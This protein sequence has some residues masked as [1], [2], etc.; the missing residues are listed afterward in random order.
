MKISVIL[1]VFI[2]KP[3]AQATVFLERSLETVINQN[4]PDDFEVIVVD[5]G[6]PEPVADVMGKTVYKTDMRIRWERLPRNS[7]LVYALNFGLRLA[8]YPFIARI[9]ADDCWRP[10]KI[11]KQMRLFEKDPD[12]SIVGT[13]MSLV[14]ENGNVLEDIV[15]PGSWDGVLDLFRNVGCPFPHGSI[16]ALKSVFMLLG[17]YP[18][19]T[20]FAHCEDFAL[21]GL[22]LR[23]F[24]PAMIEEVLYDYTVSESSVSAIHAEH[25][26][27]GSEYVHRQ[28]LSL[29]SK[30]I[31]E[32]LIR[33]GEILGLSVLDVGRLCFLIWK[34]SPT[35]TLPKPA[36][37]PMQILMPDRRLSLRRS[38]GSR[39]HP[40][41]HLLSTGGSEKTDHELITVDI[42]SP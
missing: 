9:D 38:G 42:C 30:R 11:E 29:E 13:G 26:R 3:S 20:R 6:S 16:I 14:C 37:Q 40:Q 12:L 32:A 8:K 39:R 36:L 31:P 21:W 5:D 23:F 17:G 24:K 15:R 28:F 41:V 22:W 7:G 27:N 19:A 25:Q 34:Y 2:R 18:H 4:Y 35:I 1:P 33:L 10:G